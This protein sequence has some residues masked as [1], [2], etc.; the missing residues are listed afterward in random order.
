MHRTPIFLR[1]V[2]YLFHIILIIILGQGKGMEG[3]LL[4]VGLS[5][6]LPSVYSQFTC[7]GIGQYWIIFSM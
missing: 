2:I 5:L 6:A 1:L 3:I 4:A 7:A